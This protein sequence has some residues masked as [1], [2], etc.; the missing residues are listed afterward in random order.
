MPGLARIGGFEG[1]RF[2]PRCPNVREL[3]RKDEPKLLAVAP[4]REA[5]C[6][7]TES[8]LAIESSSQA[9]V[10]APRLA[11]L[12]LRVEGLKKRYRSRRGFFGGADVAAIDDVSFTV[13][14]NEFVGVVGESGSGKSTLAKLIIGL[15]GPSSGRLELCGQDVLGRSEKARRLRI[16]TSQMVFQDPQSAL[17]PRRRVA[18]IVTQVLEAAAPRLPLSERRKRAEELLSEV[19]LS[20]DLGDRYPSQLSGGQKQR[21]NIAR[22]LCAAPKLLI[23]DEIVSGLDVSVQAQLIA[24]LRRLRRELSFALLF[25]SH[26]LAV[27]RKLCER[28]LVM[29]QGKIVEQGLTAQVFATP[30]HPYTRALIA[31]VPPDDPS[32]AWE[33][34]PEAGS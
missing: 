31:A 26:D 20:A 19:G 7:R 10:S 12:L 1:C 18:S 24:L 11:T 5:A 8:T 23:A 15:E 21:V 9:T 30:Q 29:W 13:A 27:V 28:V 3:C 16:E 14:E 4:G 22:A 34:F 33:P 6:F 2:A 32:A 25:I 17:N